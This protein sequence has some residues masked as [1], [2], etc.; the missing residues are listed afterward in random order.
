MSSLCRRVTREPGRFYRQVESLQALLGP[1]D[2]GS[3]VSDIGLSETNFLS[4]CTSLHTQTEFLSVCV[5]RE[6]DGRHR[7]TDCS[8][9]DP[10]RKSRALSLV[11]LLF[12]RVGLSL[13]GSIGRR[14]SVAI[15]R[16]ASSFNIKCQSQDCPAPSVQLM[17]HLELATALAQAASMI[18]SFAS[19]CC[20]SSVSPI[21]IA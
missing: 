9:C 4:Q 10:R 2:T 18:I 21:P 20:R 11:R 16:L 5:E 1:S 7:L 17:Q 6:P 19:A 14:D 13:P 12:L 15:T 3:R 8:A